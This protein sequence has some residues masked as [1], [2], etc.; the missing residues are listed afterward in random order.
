MGEA[1]KAAGLGVG[2]FLGL[3]A[4]GCFLGFGAAGCFLGFGAASCFLG[5]G[6]E[7]C[8]LEALFFWG[9]GEM[10]IVFFGW[11][12]SWKTNIHTFEE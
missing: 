3:G 11:K 1:P 2:Y 5:F 12:S 6:A 10:N 7:G 4:A 9:S 8:F